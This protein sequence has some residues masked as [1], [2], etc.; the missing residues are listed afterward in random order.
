MPFR[1]DRNRAGGGVIVYVRDN[2]PSKQLT[3]NRFPDDI[4][5]VFIVFTEVNLSN[6]WYIDLPSQP[7]EYFFNSVGY[8]LDICRLTYEKFFLAD[9]FNTVQTEPCLSEFLTSYDSKILYVKIFSLCLFSVHN[10]ISLSRHE[11]V[12]LMR[13]CFER[14]F[15]HHREILLPSSISR[16]VASLN[17]LVHDV[18]NLLCYSKILVKDKTYFKN[19]D[20]FITNSIGSFQK[21]TAVSSGLFGFHKMIVT[22]CESSVQ[23]SNSKEF[24]YRN[25]K[26][27]NVNRFKNVLRLK[28]QSIKFYESFE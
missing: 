8:D 7:V 26:N 18:I 19:P 3:K 14:Y 20:L 11:Q 23:K 21:T 12:C 28:L 15:S 25:Y 16:N 17:I 9:D 13:L 10:T 27:F 1:F 4:E 5:G 22:V 6:V 2:I 24:F